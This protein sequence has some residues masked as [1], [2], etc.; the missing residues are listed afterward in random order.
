MSPWSRSSRENACESERAMEESWLR[1]RAASGGGASM[2]SAATRLRRSAT[3]CRRSSALLGRD[4]LGAMRG[5]GTD[6]REGFD[7]DGDLGE[8]VLEPLS[9]GPV[10]QPIIGAGTRLFDGRG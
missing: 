6:Q 3:C 9:D 2:T 8:E 10:E 7:A 5:R 4:V 1:A